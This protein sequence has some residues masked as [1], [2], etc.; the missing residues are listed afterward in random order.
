[1]LS[2]NILVS[3]SVAV[4]ERGCGKVDNSQDADLAQVGSLA[5][6]K[7][8]EV[9]TVQPVSSVITAA[10]MP[11]NLPFSGVADAQLRPDLREY[12]AVHGCV[13][14]LMTAVVAVMVAVRHTSGPSASE[15]VI[16][17]RAAPGTFD[18]HPAHKP[19][20]DL[21]QGPNPLAEHRADDTEPPR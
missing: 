9:S 5:V 7:R 14:A 16:H 19:R 15:A 2:A 10:D 20:D 8:R 21:A 11:S 12:V 1:M 3:C 17:R 18:R 4:D 6:H 13:R